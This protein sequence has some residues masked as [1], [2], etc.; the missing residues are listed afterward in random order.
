MV[1]R[2]V[3]RASLFTDRGAI[4][5]SSRNYRYEELL[6]AS[7]GVASRLLASL[8]D[9]DEARVVIGLP[10]SFAYAAALWG[11]WRAGGI[12]VPIHT[13]APQAEIEFLFDDVQPRAV[14][15]S[16]PY[17]KA[18]VDCC[19]QRSVE[20]VDFDAS[21]RNAAITLPQISP[22]RRAL[23]LYTSGTT[24]RPKGVV[25]THAAL[26]AQIR[27]LVEAW[28][29]TSHD[30]IPLFL[31]V[32]HI[33]GVVN[34]LLCALCSGATVDVFHRFDAI[35]VLERA[36]HMGYT[37]FMAV[38][39]IYAKS[40]EALE[41]ADAPTRSRWVHALKSMRLM[42]SGSAALPVRLFD[43]WEQLTGHRLLERYGMTE[44]G[45]ALSNPLDGERRPGTVGVPLPGIE[46]R[47]RA[48][49]GQWID[50]EELP[51]ELCVRGPTLFA[52][53]W[54]RPEATEEAFVD[55]WFRTGDVAM[56]RNG[57]Y[58]I[59][60]RLSTD[61]IKSGG[62]KISALEIESALMEHPA[63]AE[64]AVVGIGDELWGEKVAAAIVLRSHTS[65]TAEALREWC[66][67][68][69]SPYKVPKAVRFFGQL[70]RNSMGKV[71]KSQ[72]R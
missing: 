43:R 64:C 34:V 5:E 51:G 9:L 16:E 26:E 61:I 69:L 1:C 8:K 60:G 39:T 7:A 32:H 31:P 52:E 48:E 55:G 6:F 10:P 70:P 46:V 54:N 30:R 13:A 45:M 66:R 4:V 35:A 11:I 68:R 53:Y 63:V 41:T 27:S 3:E 23:I 12:A 47:L 18:L 72:V 49:N 44:V 29:W 20:F 40:L 67:Q 15:S 21:C 50:Q 62:Y 17:P 22:E 33:H 19:R 24:S 36:T 59:L 25:L 42:V 14:I 71:T 57:Y 2:L 58:C 28:R 56:I 38:P 65:L 37:L